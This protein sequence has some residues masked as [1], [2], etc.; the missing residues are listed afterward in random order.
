MLKRLSYLNHKK[1][2]PKVQAKVP[3]EL[4]YSFS[5]PYTRIAKKRAKNVKTPLLSAI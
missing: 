1:D 4:N 3:L 5:Y 2:L